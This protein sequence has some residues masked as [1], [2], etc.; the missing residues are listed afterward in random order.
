MNRL[1]F[2]PSESNRLEAW[3]R[4]HRSFLLEGVCTHLLRG[5]DAGAPGGESE[6]Q[7]EALAN[8]IKAFASHS[9]L[10][11]HALNSS[12]AVNLWKRISDRA[13]LTTG[14][15]AQLGARP[16]IGIYGCEPG[17]DEEIDL[18]LKPVMTLKTQIIEVHRVQM[19][20]RVS[21]G[22]TW[23]AAAD[24]TVGVLPIGYADGYRRA[25]SNRAQVLVRGR[26][27]PQIGTVC[28]DYF[29][30]DLTAL[31][32]ET[33]TQVRLGEEVVLLGEQSNERIHPQEV[34]EWA[35]T[36]PYEILTGISERVPRV[37]I[38]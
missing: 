14:A 37:Y 32:L 22:P 23:T 2:K 26:R 7:L 28:M 35:E 15:S 34:A 17:S 9:N 29:M 25:L 24:S 5:N 33:E 8:A 3:V 6:S 27:C 38:R 18:G 36:I 19:G 11:V 13:E 4:E 21:Y 20:S 12:G 30:I 1:G 16:G 10:Y 31:E